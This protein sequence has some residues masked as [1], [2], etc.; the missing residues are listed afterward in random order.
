M[1]KTA[2]TSTTSQVLRV[3]AAYDL[4][5]TDLKQGIKAVLVDLDNT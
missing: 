4:T 5:V 2:A 3:E 1:E